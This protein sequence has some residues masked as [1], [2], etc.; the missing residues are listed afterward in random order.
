V[1]VHVAFMDMVQMPIVQII[2]MA[3][4]AHGDVSASVGMLV[5]VTFVRRMCGGHEW[6]GSAVRRGYLER[7]GPGAVSD[8]E[9]SG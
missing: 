3:F 6:K 7:A 4:M 2:E 5:L 9:R 1:F 8:L